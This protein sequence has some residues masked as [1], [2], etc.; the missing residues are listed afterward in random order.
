MTD[1]KQP[2]EFDDTQAICSEFHRYLKGGRAAPIESQLPQVDASAGET[3]D[4]P[5]VRKFRAV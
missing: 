2:N 4:Q 1:A 3:V 5:A